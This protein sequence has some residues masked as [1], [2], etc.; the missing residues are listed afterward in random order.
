MQSFK[1]IVTGG[2]ALMAAF[3]TVAAATPLRAEPVRVAVA[4]GDL[5][6]ASDAGASALQLRIARA[7]RIACGH[8]DAGTRIQ[9]ANCRLQ[10]VKSAHGQLAGRR[11]GGEVELAS[12]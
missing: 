1:N 6:I 7:A 10:A 2:A 11:Q 8:D 9:V 4:Y 3:V 12:R 5:N